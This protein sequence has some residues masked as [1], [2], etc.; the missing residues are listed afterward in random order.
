[1]EIRSKSQPNPVD[2]YINQVQAKAKIESPVSGPAQQAPK[3]DTV[4]ISETAKR[5]QDAKTR[6]DAIPDVR[7]DK[8]AEL[9][10]QI[11]NGT[12]EIQPD[13]IANKMIRESLLND[14]FK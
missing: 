12:Y 14:L 6:L 3:T 7:A 13:K 9:K 8:V 5:V 1:M 10:N 11:Q 2:A 4:D